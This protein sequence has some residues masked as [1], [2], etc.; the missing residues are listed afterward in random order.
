MHPRR[1]SSG[2]T[3]FS[4]VLG[5]GCLLA[6]CSAPGHSS[7]PPTRHDAP[8]DLDTALAAEIKRHKLTGN[9]EGVAAAADIKSPLAQLGKQLFFSKHLS[10]TGTVACVSCH[11]PLLGGGDGLALPVGVGAH[12]PDLLGPGRRYDPHLR[13]DSLADFGPNVPRHSPTTFNIALYNRAMFFDGRVF[14]T[15]D[16]LRPHGS[17]QAIRTP[18]SIQNFPDGTA[19]GDLSITQAKFPITSIHEMRGVHEHTGA[20][21]DDIRAT[22]VS[23][24]MKSEN[25]WAWLRAFRAA[26]RSKDRRGPSDLLNYET[27]TYDHVAQA[28]SAYQRSQLFIESP[29]RRYVRGERTALDESA[30]RGALLFFRDADQGG[31]GC[32]GCHSGDHFSDEKFHILAIPQIGIGKTEDSGDHG[33]HDVTQLETDRYAFR[34]PALLNVAVTGPYGHSGVYNTLGEIIR[35]HLDPE[36]M[37]KQFREDSV[38]QLHELGLRYAECAE[39]NAE[40]L[41]ALAAARAEGRSSLPPPRRA[42]DEQIADVAKFL[43]SLTDPCTRDPACLRDWI[44]GPDEAL[45]SSIQQAKFGAFGEGLTLAVMSPR[46]PAPTL[47]GPQIPTAPVDPGRARHCSADPSPA[48]GN[49]AGPLFE[50]IGA[51]IGLSHEYRVND[52]TWN[53]AD[54]WFMEA[55]LLTGGSAAG[56]V[57]G[58]CRP[59]LIVSLGEQVIMLTARDGRFDRTVLREGRYSGPALAD[60]DNDGAL[61]L[62]LAGMKGTSSVWLHNDGSGRFT[63]PDKSAAWPLRNDLNTY[64]AAFADVD[65]DGDLDAYVTRWD[66]STTATSPHLWLN[67]GK[68]A[69]TAAGAEWGVERLYVG[70][71]ADTSFSPNFVDLNQDG[72]PDLVVAED[73]ERSKVYI[74]TQLAGTDKR[75]FRDATNRK[76]IT[77]ENGMGAAIADFD[78]DGDM[79]WFVTSIRGKPTFL[80]M[81]GVSGNRL[82]LNKG[83]GTFEDAT[84]R[85]GVRDGGWGWG[86]CAVDLDND[87]RL[88][89]YHVNGYGDLPYPKLKKGVLPTKLIP[90]YQNAFAQYLDKPARLFMGEGGGKFIDRAEQEGAANDGEGRGVSCFDYDRDGDVDIFIVDHAGNSRFLRNNARN[91]NKNHFA[92]LRLWQRRANPFAIGAKVEL[93]VGNRT[94]VQYVAH[95]NNYLSQN[96][97]DLHFGLGE[98]TRI[99]SIKVTWPDGATNRYANLPVDRFLTLERQRPE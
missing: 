57:N 9:P 95:Y 98:H 61:D 37:V 48:R 45:D 68:G 35:H 2:C 91:I 28:L 10:L 43:E 54:V 87:G 15:D 53:N 94:Y 29:W 46:A 69:F 13:A 14:V 23:R 79:D 33:R 64:G 26:F 47:T 56:D 12:D 11:H 32:A 8:P 62:F 44:P 18:E 31:F 78:Q 59:D 67:N 21:T 34:T 4:L 3:W 50:E 20:T 40:A 92:S 71:G 24:L 75:G 19:G 73:F 72:W 38:P 86:T 74:N 99:D 63:E 83:D 93:T 76:V 58:D 80:T 85:A 39:H 6:S 51:S 77:D 66:G 89:I 65:K 52:T 36:A 7:A 5:T 27:I 97:L 25:A 70:K 42:T 81:F 41:N 60:L 49:N 16:E 30:R 17:G 82:Y 88:D 22:L 96:P 1:R 90:K 84:D 55:M